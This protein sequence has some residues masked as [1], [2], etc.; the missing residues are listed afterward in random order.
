MNIQSA[1]ELR[2]L[3]LR[4]FEEKG[5]ARIPS[6]SV[7]P[8]NDPTVL[9]TTAG[10][11]PL[12]PYLMGE[13]HPMGTRLTDVQKCIR[14]GDIDDVGDPSH[15]TFFE[16]L[17]N[18]SL[19]DYFKKE[20][21]PWSWEFL[22]S[23]DWL[24]LDPDKLAFTVFEGDAD[25]PRDE[26][27][28][29]L[30]RAQGVKDDHLF[31]LPKKHNWW[32][33]AG[34]TGPCGPDTEM[35]IIR[36]QPPCGSD[37]SPACSCGRYLEIWND[38][39]M[40]YEKQA[41]GTF[42]PL[43]Q[44]NVDTGMGLERTYCVLKGA[45]TVYETEIFAGIIGKIEELSGKKYG[46]DEE[47]TRAI[48]IISD[49]M[50]TATFIIGDDRGV[51]PSNVDQGYVLRRLIRRAVRH[52]MKL[53]M[54]AGFTCEIARVIIDQYKSV[55]PE[56]ERNGAHILEQLKLEE[57]RFQRTLRKGM[58]EFEKVYGNMARKKEAFTALK[59]NRGDPDAV[60]AALRQ[61]PPSPDNKPV[62]EQVKDGTISDETI[63]AL[64]KTC[65][66]MDGRSAF[67][68][69]D[70]Y[71]FPVEITCEM[72]AEKGIEVDVEGFNERFKK[73]QENSHAGAEQRFKGGLADHSE[74]TAK[75]HTATHLLHAALRKVLGPEVA[76]K[77]SNITAE[78]LRFD[79][80]FG[81]KMTDEEKAE[82]ERLVN[83]YI[84]AAAPITCE[85]MTVAEAKA[86]GAIGL[87]ESKYGERVKVYTMGEFSKEIC[88]G[89]H[90]T[91]TGDLKSFKIKKEEASSAGVRRIKA[92]IGQ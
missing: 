38:V 78:R 39:F 83:S 28:A 45:N 57:E 75:L 60:A 53:G 10:M 71:G 26:E 66:K 29:N 77:G 82:V 80:S 25:C 31:Y 22:T 27:A 55:Y 20:M 76:Q 6:A 85:E 72:A 5:H 8:E 9:F 32:G 12:V 17:G 33:P 15:L 48:R 91:N 37:C 34:I 58:A 40:Q 61:L 68:L 90:A 30:W 2:S 42:I 65:E 43:K 56:L 16:M 87:F 41:D 67:K 23:P 69:Y 81:R 11:H 70:T 51:T 44:K 54:E 24:G 1:N 36:D 62:I 74:E 88:G 86:Q 89:P 3:F 21:I 49:H 13:K 18:W 64:L 84:Q 79:F 63:D 50:R 92:V 59:A 73:H 46:Q 47:T 14:T 19:G 4:F 7:I 35:F 52:G